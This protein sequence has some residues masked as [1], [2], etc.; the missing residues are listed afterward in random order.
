MPPLPKPIAAAKPEGVSP[1]TAQAD[2]RADGKTMPVSTPATSTADSS[3]ITPLMPAPGAA[4]VM[5]IPSGVAHIN[6]TLPTQTSSTATSDGPPPPQ[7]GAVPS[8]PMQTGSRSPPH[9][10]PSYPIQAPPQ[11]SIPAPTGTALHGRSTSTATTATSIGTGPTTLDLGPVSS[12]QQSHHE[13]GRPEGYVQNPFAADPSPQQRAR[14]D[15]FASILPAPTADAVGGSSETG[16][17]GVWESV[18]E[19][20][21]AAGTK[22]AEAEAEVWKR[23]NKS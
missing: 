13:Y 6:K 11:T 15:A 12:A 16:G 20:A 8:A 10:A 21:T 18:K 5:P 3:S 19:M 2:D 17:N 1:A 9:A 22:V 4:A 23:I 7:P 14:Q